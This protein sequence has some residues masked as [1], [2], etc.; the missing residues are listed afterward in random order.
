SAQGTV[1]KAAMIA[2]AARITKVM[3]TQIGAFWRCK[4]QEP[5]SKI[6]PRASN[7]VDHQGI[8]V[9]LTSSQV[10]VSPPARIVQDETVCQSTAHFLPQ[11]QSLHHTLPRKLVVD[12]CSGSLDQRPSL[13]RHMN[14]KNRSAD[15]LAQQISN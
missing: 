8:R 5:P 4:D 11:Q 15:R 1:T 2:S 3:R 13:I 9:F 7:N 10:V 14:G 12:T 6:P